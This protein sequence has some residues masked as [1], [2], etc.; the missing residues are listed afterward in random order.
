MATNELRKQDRDSLARFL[1][2]FSIGLGTAQ[3]AMPRA[4]SRLIGA[5]GDGMFMRLMGVRELTH[6]TAILTRPRPTAGVWSRVGGDAL[7]L[8][9]LLKVLIDGKGRK[10]TLFA[11]AQVAPIVAADVYEARFLS[12]KQGEPTR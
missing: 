1:G 12:Q 9:A 5:N 10:R 3:L 7:D 11:L 6:G 4:L 2:W 8:V